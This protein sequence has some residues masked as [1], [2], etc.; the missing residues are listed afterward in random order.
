MKIPTGK[1]NSIRYTVEQ[2]QRLINGESKTV[3]V[4][5]DTHLEVDTEGDYDSRETCQVACGEANRLNPAP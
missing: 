1:S 2:R 3:W 4:V 5:Y